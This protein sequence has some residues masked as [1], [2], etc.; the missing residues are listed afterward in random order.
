MPSG[1][2]TLLRYWRV[3]LFVWIALLLGLASACRAGQS[4]GDTD[5]PATAA[6]KSDVV[7]FDPCQ[8]LTAADVTAALPTVSVT[9]VPEPMTGP[10]MLTASGPDVTASRCVY[11]LGTSGVISAAAGQYPSADETHTAYQL[12]RAD[13]LH[14]EPAGQKTE[15]VNGLGDEALLAVNDLGGTIIVRAGRGYIFVSWIGD[16]IPSAAGRM[17]GTTMAGRIP[18]AL[19]AQGKGDPQRSLASACSWLDS[20]TLAAV[21]GDAHRGMD[22]AI[23]LPATSA[24]A[25]PSAALPFQNAGCTWARRG[26]TL[27]AEVKAVTGMAGAADHESAIDGVY[28]G[29]TIG[30]SVGDRT[31]VVTLRGDGATVEIARMLSDA[32]IAGAERSGWAALR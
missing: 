1:H 21:F 8:S 28:S 27:L 11:D 30:R 18:G 7:P 19:R 2:P 22:T 14:V 15:D 25:R 10:G 3:S 23:Q 13:V 24:S 5:V 6:D 26:G 16:A 29:W 4:A 17:L 9:P 20:K 31:M 12:N 32:A